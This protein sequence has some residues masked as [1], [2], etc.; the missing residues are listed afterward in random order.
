MIS[1]V[2][3]F[4]DPA[5]TT[6]FFGLGGQQ[7]VSTTAGDSASVLR[8]AA[9]SRGFRGRLTANAAGTV[10]F[11]LFVNG[12]ASSVTCSIPAGQNAC[13]DGTNTATVAAGD[14][15]TVRLTN[16]S[17]MLRHVSW[18]AKLS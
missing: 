17:G 15:V 16:A 6:G 9:R 2:V 10:T 4:V 13:T 3:T 18:S 11:T 12:A 1:G 7:N 14:V 8:P 5:D